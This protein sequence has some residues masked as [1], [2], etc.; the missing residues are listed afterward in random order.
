M[1]CP[2]C[3]AQN[4]DHASFCDECGSRIESACPSCGEP[5]R[6][7]AKFCKKCGQRLI[8]KDA[9]DA[10]AV[11]RFG[12]PDTYTP[13]HLAEKILLS[14]AAL[15]G[16]RKV[17]TTLFA[18][19]KGSM[20]LLAD[21]DPEEAH[22]LLDPVVQRMMDA[23]H[24]YEGTVT[25]VR[26]DG[27]MALFGAPLAHEDHAQ[28]ACYAALDMQAAIRRYA[29]EVR[30][31]HG[32]TAQIRV[33]LNSGGVVV[34][35]IG[36]DLRM[37]Y[38][39][40][41]ESTHLAARME[42][43]AN[44]G[45][46]FLTP[47]T[48]RLAEGYI[49]V[50]SLGPVPVKGLKAPVEIY[51]L[52]GAGPVRSRLHAAV[53]RGLTR[54]VG[55]ETELE[56]IRKAL[57][58]SASGH[59]QVVAVVGEAGVGKSRLVWEVTH[60]HRTDGWRVVQASSV[61]FGRATPYLAV[62][63]LLKGYFQ[64]EDQDDYRQIREKLTGKLLT[65]DRALEPTLPP[66]L[67]LLDVPVEDATWQALDPR[68]RRQR[69][70][71]AVKGLL[72]R[73]SQVQPLLVIF[74]DLHWIDSETQALLDSLVETIPTA[75]VLLLANYRPEYDHR[76]GSKTYYTQLGL[77]PLPPESADA[78]LDALLGGD[79]S[80]EPLK[81][82]LIERTQGNPFFLEESVQTL[83]EIEALQG[84]RG[85]Y[86]MARPIDTIQV[87]TTVQALITARIDRLPSEEKRLLETAAV[88]GKDVPFALLQAVCGQD[89]LRLRQGLAH[90]QVM[91][92]LYE[93]SLFPDLEYT[94]K[95]AL[96]HEVAYGILLN[97]QRR[98]LHAYIVEAMQRLYA[99]RLTEQV[100]QL[101]HHA[102]RGEQWEQAVGY[103]RQA[104]AKA[105]GR[106]AYP[107]AA[108]SLEQALIALNHLPEDRE[109]RQQGVDLRFDLRSALQAL[110][111]H[112]RV[113]DHLHAAEVLA[114]ELQ[115]QVRLGWASAYLSQYLW[116]MRDPQR[117]EE[118]GQR[119]LSLASARGDFP[120]EVVA[121]FFLGQGYFNVGDY[122]RASEHCRRNTTMLEGEHAFQRFGLTGL[123]AVL[124]HIWL[125]WSLAEQGDFAEAMVPAEKAL[126][127]AESAGQ[128][129]SVAAACLAIG[130]V[131]L[132]RGALAEAIPVLE[133]SAELCGNAKLQ[134]ILT[135]TTALLGLARALQGHFREA[136]P[137]M[138]KNEA[139][140][141]EIRIFN[142]STA[143]I[144]LGTVRLIAGKADEAREMAA[145]A[146]ERAADHG[147]RGSQARISH[148]LGDIYARREA[149]D[150]E[151]AKQ[152][153][154]KSMSLAE[155]LGMRPLVAQC[156]LSLGRLHRQAAHL[157]QAVEHFR[158]MDMPFWLQQA[159]LELR[160][161]K[162]RTLR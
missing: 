158:A 81:R 135:T 123:P 96:T 139:H 156:H 126:S 40:V 109:T 121:N 108:A 113:F 31:A 91:E 12:S 72:F 93:T 66:L 54:F 35:A 51:E 4:P 14:R 33:G 55:R 140:A 21:R 120:L 2:R 41:G 58:R 92:F 20:E 160:N 37:D 13:K 106:S 90:L 22:K 45:S 79:P 153:Y 152:H 117:A 7:T 26:G 36:S 49:E 64:I 99:D 141:P 43:L 144:A 48:L 17:V 77:D 119:A 63:D 146:A 111:D 10:A 32:V 86:R 151:R 78:L 162:H 18:D 82:L 34:R 133:R 102:F 147:F 100:D 105:A 125:A 60:S 62:V 68:E 16:E 25:E 65:L 137:E 127:I 47:D 39:A 56:Q 57:E 122:A 94:F 150:M 95:H 23:V 5:N 76:W 46:T 159:E 131:Q 61:T 44:P 24:R 101:A 11:S 19:L 70:L 50:K 107:E 29:E 1:E 136:L 138:E 67:A 161:A 38:A 9:G 83:V 6:P 148:L 52:I 74:E 87:P 155:G 69:T 84:E 28:R 124:S 154:R 88:I 89:E 104:G 142:T 114:S 53:A 143:T 157:K 85:A 112:Q 149:P 3:H 115:D 128:V 145:H 132:V 75:R 73:E 8:L 27:I 134:V 110:G 103:L 15:E 118:T 59:G 97:E 130:Q 30:R 129:Y 42:Q 116:R 80:L 98:Q 71:A